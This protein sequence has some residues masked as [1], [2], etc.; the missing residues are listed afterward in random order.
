MVNA[1]PWPLYPWERPGT[2]CTGGWVGPTAGLDGGRKFHPL[3]GFDSQ[4]IRP[5]ASGYTGYPGPRH[6]MYA[7]ITSI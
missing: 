3:P 7:S 2:Q 6:Y 5:V 1:K 4:T